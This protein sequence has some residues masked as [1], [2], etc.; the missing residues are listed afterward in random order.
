[1]YTEPYDTRWTCGECCLTTCGLVGLYLCTRGDGARQYMPLEL[2]EFYAINDLSTG[3][4]EA[5]YNRDEVERRIAAY[6]QEDKLRMAAKLPIAVSW[7]ET[8]PRLQT[9]DMILFRCTDTYGSYS[10]TATTGEFTHIGLVVLEFDE[11]NRKA[12]LLFESVSDAKDRLEDYETGAVKSGVRQVDLEDRLLS[13]TSHYYGVVKL[14]YP[15][16]ERELDVRRRLKRFTRREARK[17]Y[18]HNKLNLCHVAFNRVSLC[19]TACDCGDVSAASAASG[20]GDYPER[21]FCSQLV[22]KALQEAGVLDQNRLNAADT[23]PSD[24]F[25]HNLPLV[26]GV[27]VE[28]LYYMARLDHPSVAEAAPAPKRQTASAPRP[29]PQMGRRSISEARVKSA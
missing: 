7:Y 25:Q 20:A 28:A 29:P 5:P 27:E 17:L 10:V 2:R 6:Q 21:Y 19:H 13:S 8:R 18:D 22:C 26:N 11:H 4:A 1:M 3:R 23:S 16:A 14:R 12:I 24:F 9:G 15:S